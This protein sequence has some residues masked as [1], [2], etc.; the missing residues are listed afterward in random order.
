M[1]KLL[2]FG[3][4]LV[5][6]GSDMILSWLNSDLDEWWLRMKAQM[7]EKINSGWPESINLIKIKGTIDV[8]D[9]KK[10]TN[11]T[12]NGCIVF[13][14]SCSMITMISCCGWTSTCVCKG[15]RVYPQWDNSLTIYTRKVITTFWQ[16]PMRSERPPHW[17]E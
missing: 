9:K 8:K 2:P 4:M 5:L 7:M 11:E 1:L 3:E 16:C 17:A 14:N 15:Q 13:A 12:K 10:C 6:R